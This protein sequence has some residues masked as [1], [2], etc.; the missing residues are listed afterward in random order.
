MCTSPMSDDIP[1][2]KNLDLA[3][4]TVDEPMR[5]VQRVMADNPGPFTFN[6]T[7]SYIV[8]REGAARHIR[9]DDRVSCAR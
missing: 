7:L 1:F 6:D 3:P 4:D 2:D 9:R 5:G 8:S